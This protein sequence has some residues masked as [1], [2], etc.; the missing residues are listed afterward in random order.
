MQMILA[1]AAG[2]AVGSVLRYLAGKYALAWAGND[3]PYGTLFVNIS[4][5]FI[6][7]VLIAL[8]AVHVSPSAEVRAFLTVGM[9]GGFT[10]FSAFSL[11]TVTLW[12]RGDVILALSYAGITVLS[13]IAALVAGLYLIRSLQ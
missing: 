5:S 9:L 10:T 3:F 6:M 7:G 1:V 13:S 2:G 11:D 4:G 12:E 8:F